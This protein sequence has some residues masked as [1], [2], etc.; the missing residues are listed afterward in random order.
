[1]VSGNPNLRNLR[2]SRL[3]YIP[4]PVVLA[5]NQLMV[6]H[7]PWVAE[8]GE[9]HCPITAEFG[10]ASTALPPDLFLPST[11][12]RVAVLRSQW[13]IRVWTCRPCRI[14]FHGVT[15]LM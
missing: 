14:D 12:L 8:R 1:M 13:M 9:L 7:R 15:A 2:S 5:E 4:Y 3:D 11:E 6:G 10:L